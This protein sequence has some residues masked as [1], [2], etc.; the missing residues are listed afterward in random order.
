[1]YFVGNVA[2]LDCSNYVK[3]T[4]PFSGKA[5]SVRYGAYL[6]SRLKRTVLLHMGGTEEVLHRAGTVLFQQPA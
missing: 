3:E 2:V 1:M 4:K 5:G 6:L